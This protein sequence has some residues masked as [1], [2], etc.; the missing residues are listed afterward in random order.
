MNTKIFSILIL[1]LLTASCVKQDH[2]NPF[3]SQCP[4]ELWTPTDFKATLEGITVKL[5]WNQTENRI[6]GFKLTKKV[7]T[8]TESALTNQSKDANQLTDASLTGGKVHVYTLVAYAGN[9]QSNVVTAQI[10]PTFLATVTTASANSITANS[11]ILGGTITTDGGAAITE[12]GIC[13]ATTANPTTAANKLAIGTGNGSFSNTI[14]GLLPST[15]YYFRAYATNSVG[16]AYGNEVTATALAALPT[17]T[18]TALSAVTSTMA[19]SG[20]NITYEGIS[21]VTARGV[22]WSTTPNPT[23]SNPKTTDGTGSGTFTSS[24]TGFLPGT[25]YYVRAYATN[26]GGTAYGNEVTATT[27]VALPTIITAA[28]SSVTSTTATSGG[29]ITYEGISAVT[30][31]G[32]CWSTTPN[33]TTSNPKTTD[34]T[35]PGTFTS[36][37]NGLLPGTTYY[38]RAY[39]TNGVGTVYGNELTATITAILPVITTAAAT[40]LSMTSVTIGGTITTDGGSTVVARGVCWS[41]TQNPTIANSKTTDGTGL[42]TFVSSVTGLSPATTYYISAYATNGVGTAYG[43]PVT[44]LTEPPVP[45][46]ILTTTAISALTATTATS[47]GNISNNSGYAVT[48]RGVCWATTQNP[49][50]ANSLT[51]DGSGSGVFTSNISGLLPS[52]TYYIRAYAT[53]FLKTAYGTQV[54][55]TTSSTS[56]ST[57]TDIDGNVYNTVTIGTQVW[58]VENLKTTKYRNG[59]PIPNVTVDATWGGLTTG[60]YCWYNNDAAT[61]KATYGALYNWYAVADSRNI[62]PA[63]WHVPTDAE[64]TT[65]TTYLGGENVAGDKLKEVGTAHWITTNTGVTNISGFT[66]LPGGYRNMGIGNYSFWWSSTENFAAATIWIRKMYISYSNVAREDWPK[67]EGFYVR[68]LRD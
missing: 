17:L 27:L 30:A 42:G 68:C 41:T 66:A 45:D 55:F 12:R 6:S 60:A 3:D 46:V 37:I 15:L 48:V 65:L 33:P 61:Y 56:G 62:A 31:R 58:M 52:T 53:N 22:C 8:G 34:G 57:V 49:T 59:D 18:T 63:G 50:I 47:G 54:S 40:S 2:N 38:V 64:W 10:T 20:G 26:S 7:D 51:N 21:A 16:T 23:I 43:T 29:N 36:S 4:K 25:A 44:I 24:I 11:A 67:N 13:W 9:N 28:L 1:L 5:T 19:T 14:P 35:G 39:A 32:V